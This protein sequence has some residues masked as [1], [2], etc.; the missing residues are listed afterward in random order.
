VFR[1]AVGSIFKKEYFFIL[2]EF[3]FSVFKLF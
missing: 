1:A 2:N 3:Y